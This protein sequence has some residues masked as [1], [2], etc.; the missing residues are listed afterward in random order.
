MSSD[1]C[2][3]QYL[4]I[5]CPESRARCNHAAALLQSGAGQISWHRCIGWAGLYRECEGLGC[6]HCG[7]VLSGPWDICTSNRWGNCSLKLEKKA[8]FQQLWLE[9]TNMQLIFFPSPFSV[10]WQKWSFSVNVRLKHSHN[11]GCVAP[12]RTHLTHNVLP[13]I[14]GKCFLISETAVSKHCRWTL[15][16]GAHSVCWQNSNQMLRSEVEPCV[17]FTPGTLTIACVMNL[18]EFILSCSQIYMWAI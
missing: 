7:A 18:F 17:N 6:S 3:L 12:L 8:R 14:H 5:Y 15:Q 16:Q 2:C 4:D 10:R 9:K 13:P 1:R 11:Q